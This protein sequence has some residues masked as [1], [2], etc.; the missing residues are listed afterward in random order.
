M[1]L[2][3]EASASGASTNLTQV[4]GLEI[5]DFNGGGVL[6]D[7]ASY[8]KLN[9]LFVGVMNVGSNILDEGNGSFGISFNGGSRDTLSG[10]VVAANQSTGVYVNAATSDTLTGD[11]I[12]TDVT[13]ELSVDQ[14]GKSLGNNGTG[15]FIGSV[16]LQHRESYRRRQQ[17]RSGR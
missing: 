1:G 9:D 7:G 3:I 6:V 10:S 2:D 5:T 12:G 17:Q 13:G 4:S 16:D 8:V 11:F 15:V 14:N